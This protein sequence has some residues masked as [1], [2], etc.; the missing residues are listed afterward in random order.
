Q[1][2]E[3]GHPQEA[4][5][6]VER[7]R[8]QSFLALLAERDLAFAAEIPASLDRERR[9]LTALY[10]GNELRLAT[11]DPDRERA[12]IEELQREQLHLRGQRA[13]VAAKIHEASPRLAAML[14]PQPLSFEQVRKALDSGTVMLSYNVGAEET[15]L[16][17]VTPGKDL[18]VKT[19]PI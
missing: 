16:F 7:F 8:A 14:Q 1:E 5:R 11:L 18:A 19:L 6:L 2:I 9:R 4:F 15:E 3:L 12:A 17:V 13:E 10:D